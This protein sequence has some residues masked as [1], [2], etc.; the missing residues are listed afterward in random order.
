M[1]LRDFSFFRFRKMIHWTTKHTFHITLMGSTIGKGK[2]KKR[3]IKK[4]N[5][6]FLSKLSQMISV[7]VS[8]LSGVVAL[9]LL[10]SNCSK[11]K[12]KMTH[13]Y[14]KYTFQ[15]TL[16]VVWLTD[17]FFFFGWSVV[18]WERNYNNR[19]KVEENIW[20]CLR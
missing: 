4:E 16:L 2:V 13:W 17:C 6:Y 7:L 9:A 11:G 18:V 8:T 1:L 14:E 3:C 19:K 10:C 20:Q 12:R 15:L 5:I